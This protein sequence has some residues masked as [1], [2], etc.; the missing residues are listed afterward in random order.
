MV[1]EC[2]RV[3]NLQKPWGVTDPRPWTKPA[4][5]G[6]AIGEICYERTTAGATEP[7][8]LLKILL[9]SQ[10]LSI[11]VHPDDSFA[12]SIGLPHGKTEAWYVL[13][14]QP[15]A[16]IAVGLKRDVTPADLRK[17]VDDGSIADLVSW[18]SVTC[19]ET[20]SVPAGTI[21]AIG[22]GLVIAEIQQR[23]D[24]TFRLFD[25]GRGRELHKDQGLAVARA[26]PA[27]GERQPEM[28][29]KGR[30]LLAVNSHFVFERLELE[31]DSN[32]RLDVT[33]ESWLVVLCGGARVGGFDLSRGEAVFAEKE[34]VELRPGPAGVVCLVA[35][36]GRG[37]P[38]PDL[39]L[40]GDRQSSTQALARDDAA[41]VSGPIGAT[42]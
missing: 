34:R 31:P 38:N 28:L 17:A 22:P 19:G 3:R 11:Q 27:D 29:E 21:H 12:Q 33:R 9:T 16:A 35:Y 7:A 26:T 4:P 14:A 8:L 40:R 41:A 39:L 23:S 1:V 20:V 6:S 36:T 30:T 10:A 18:R 5:A 32:W 24:T 15:G 13:G 37:G 42:Q 25:H 2:A